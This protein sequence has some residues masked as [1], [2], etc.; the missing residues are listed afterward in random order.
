MNLTEL[1]D[2]NFKIVTNWQECNKNS[3]F[4]YQNSNFKNFL[5]YRNLAVKKKCKFIICDI[6]FK[7]NIRQN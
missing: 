7:K 2:N 4:L 3:I 1:K 5:T 6:K